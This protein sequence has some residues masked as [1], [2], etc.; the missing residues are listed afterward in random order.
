MHGPE[1]DYRSLRFASDKLRAD[2][3]L[4]LELL[5]INGLALEFAVEELRADREVVSCALSQNGFTILYACANEPD[6][7]Q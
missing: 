3:E 1:T 2:R 4:F 5:P 6:P 7:K